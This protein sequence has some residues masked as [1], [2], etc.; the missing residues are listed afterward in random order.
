MII[1]WNF[2]LSVITAIAAIVALFLS[3]RQIQLSNK[4]QLFERRLNAY[5]ITNG[6]I[7]LYKKNKVFLEQKKRK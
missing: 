5:I 2:W 4:Q 1:D 3:V 7:E 6:L